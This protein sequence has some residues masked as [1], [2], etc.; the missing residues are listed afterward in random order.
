M[1]REGNTKILILDLAPVE[2]KFLL[3][4]ALVIVLQVGPSQGLQAC[5]A[6]N[7]FMSKNWEVVFQELKPVVDE[8]ISALLFDIAKKVFD[9]F[10]LSQLFPEG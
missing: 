4:V 8:A 3:C 5:D 10:P 2:M 9:R 1:R 6:M 7:E